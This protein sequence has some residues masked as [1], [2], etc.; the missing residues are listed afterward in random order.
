MMLFVTFVVF[1]LILSWID[2]REHRLPNYLIG[3]LIIALLLVTASSEHSD[4]MAIALQVTGLYL[5]AFSVLYLLSRGALGLGDV[6]FAIPCGFV[7]GVLAPQNWLI[8]VWLMFVMAGLFG[9]SRVLIDRNAY[10]K[11]IPFGPFM[12]T[13]VF[14]FGFNSLYLG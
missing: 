2:V 10:S 8:C 3:L 6:K 7:I 5:I 12:T 13:S 1:A 9:L 4:Q 11:A 14:I